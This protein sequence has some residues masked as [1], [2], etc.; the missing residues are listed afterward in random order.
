MGVDKVKFEASTDGK[1]WIPINDIHMLEGFLE[2]FFENPMV[3]DCEV[4][5]RKAVE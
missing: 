2:G 3:S 5:L 4:K 1:K